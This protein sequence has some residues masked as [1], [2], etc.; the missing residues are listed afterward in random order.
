MGSG[1]ELSKQKRQFIKNSEGVEPILIPRN[2]SEDMAQVG[3]TDGFLVDD[4]V[5]PPRHSTSAIR[6]DIPPGLRNRPTGSYQPTSVIPPRRQQVQTKNVPMRPAPRPI[7]PSKKKPSQHSPGR[8]HWLLPIGVAMVLLVILWMVGSAT[9][10]W[11]KQKLN[12]LQYGNP[13]TF[14]T[15]AVVGHGDSPKNPSHFIAMNLHSQI[16]VIEFMGGNPEKAITYLVPV[17][18]TGSD[19]SLAPATLEF[20]DVNGDGKPDMLV[21]IHLPQQ[22]QFS[23]FI[24]TGTKFRPLNAS[25]KITT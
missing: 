18:I 8:V 2:T 16:I 10:A 9:L 12:D 11:G 22:D 23:V 17:F 6:L 3:R 1:G 13:R 25:D 4:G 20:R 21:H 24:N 19:G 15:D 5:E 14:Q 7:S